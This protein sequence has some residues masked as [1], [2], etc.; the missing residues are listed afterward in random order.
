MATVPPPAPL[1]ASATSEEAE[2]DRS[3]ENE[4]GA[5]R[6]EVERFNEDHR[7]AS[8]CFMSRILTRKW[9][10]QNMN[11]VMHCKRCKGTL[12]ID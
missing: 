6:D 11:F 12:N 9:R 7:V 5:D 4:R 10:N 8:L 2:D 1:E 3:H